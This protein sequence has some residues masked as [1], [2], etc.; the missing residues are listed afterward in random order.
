MEPFIVFQVLFV[1]CILPYVI[2]VLPRQGFASVKLSAT[3][4]ETL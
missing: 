4:V 3:A 1:S 2:Y